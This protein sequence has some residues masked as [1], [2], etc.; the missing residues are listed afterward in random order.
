[1]A[2]TDVKLESVY[3][4]YKHKYE[5]RKE[6]YFAPLFLAEKFGNPL[7][8]MMNYSSFGNNDYGIDAYFIDKE[9]RN[10]Y[11]F[12]FKWSENCNLFNESY[13]RLIKSGMER[14][15][16]DPL[17][18]P[19]LN[20]LISKLV[21]EINEYKD[22]INKV[23]I[24]FVFNGDVEKAENS[25]TLDYKKEELESKKFLID[26]FFKHSK[27]SFA[28]QY[29]SNESREVLQVSRTDK[30]FAY[31]LD[32]KS[33]I[34]QETQ[35]GELMYVGVISLYDLYKMY[36][37][38]KSKLFERNI[39]Y[40][41]NSSLEPNRAIY[42]ML[43]SIVEEK[44]VHPEHFIFHHNGISMFAERLD[45]VDDF[46][47]VYEPRIL[48]G[49]QTISSY[50][51]YFEDL[52]QKPDSGKYEFL[53]KE[54]CVICK[55]I[56]NC[57]KEFVTK[58]TISNNKQ[59]PVSSWNLRANDLIQVQ[60]EDKFLSH[61]IYYERQDNSYKNKTYSELDEIGV[62]DKKIIQIRPLAQTF[63]AIQGEIGK[64]A[65][66]KEIF[67]NVTIYQQAFHSDFLS[68][69]T[70]KIILAYK[71]YLKSNP[72]IKE[73]KSKSENYNYFSKAKNLVFAL[74][75]QGIFNDK[76]LEG[77]LKD[78]GESMLIDADFNV[79]IKNLASTKVKMIISELVRLPKYSTKF[80][81]EKF[82]FFRS[83]Q[84]FIDS[85][86]IAKEKYGWG[87]K[88]LI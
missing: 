27:I 84:V 52:K 87:V 77:N 80:K 64:I 18:D 38:M 81:E 59:N 49:A 10:L 76:S 19:K 65:E 83:N 61:G 58:V 86:K 12:Q 17:G 70:R 1:M 11:L 16:G 43:R 13:D 3:K 22:L 20:K 42:K 51:K 78:H 6:D 35:S 34:K 29:E 8:E 41:L 31:K 46:T 85:M 36:A 82:D 23:Y 68:A 60:F 45:T 79:Y 50:A 7:E 9:T 21:N 63:L 75:I 66:I 62:I 54:I 69:D 72:I 30:T 44:N 5:G 14:I 4:Q 71:I 39:R 25:R 48:N 33:H 32:F 47:K 26:E 67:E 73:I 24:S 88:K 40:A 57:E 74:T 55:I 56:T 15:F 2:I 28:I 37:E 53:L